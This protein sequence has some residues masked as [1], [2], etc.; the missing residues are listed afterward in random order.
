ML[1]QAIEKWLNQYSDESTDELT[2]AILKT[3]I[4]V[5]NQLLV[6]KAVLLPWAC[7][8]FLEA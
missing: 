3:V 5:A 1:R 8:V 4:F 7:Q 2:K 6:E